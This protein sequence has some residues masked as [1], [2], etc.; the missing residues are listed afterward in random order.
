MR[1]ASAREPKHW[2][3]YN[4]PKY[5]NLHENKKQEHT[6]ELIM[7]KKAQQNEISGCNDNIDGKD[8]AA[9]NRSLSWKLRINELDEA[10]YH[11]LRHLRSVA[12]DARSQFLRLSQQDGHEK[13]R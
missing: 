13:D 4:A 9:A 6:K 7:P 5:A 11:H 1:V 2:T 3:R 8:M 10:H 12:K